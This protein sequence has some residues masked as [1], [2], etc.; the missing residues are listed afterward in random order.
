M[1]FTQAEL[2][3]IANTTLDY[4]IRGEALSQIIQARPL[5]DAMRKAQKTF[6]GGKGDISLPVKGE[7]TT[8][9]AGYS[10]D[11][12]VTFV[13]PANVKRVNYAWR[14]HHAG[15]GVTLTELKH[16]GISVVDSAQSKSTTQHSE[17]ELVVLTN[18]LQDKLEDMA[19]GWARS[20]TDLLF[21]DGATDPKALAGLAALLPDDPTSGTVGGIDRATTAWWRH[22]ART[23][24]H[25]TATTLASDGPI[26]TGAE[27]ID[28]VIHTEMRQL[29]RYRGKPSLACCGSDFLDALV[30]KLRS[31]GNYTDSGWSSKGVTDIAMADV[32]YR[33]MPFVYDPHM[34]DLGLAK[35]CYI[36]DPS[37]IYL[38]AMEGED[39]KRHT[40]ARPHDKYV[41]Y[42][43]LTW[44]GQ[45]V[46]QQSNAQGVYDIA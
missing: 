30:A 3:N 22:R 7:Y 2:D 10:H 28:N 26:D 40:P 31:K 20:F 21:D 27:E 16:S 39:M 42:R 33:N 41:M 25:Q 29:K 46:L 9:V 4:F 11:D 5:Y 38:Y 36:L 35:R 43:S 23:T 12:T 18:L 37:K 6:P 44:T 19:E 1:A 34:D 32:H 8:S 45:M 13:N 17:S 24:A 14:E 15:I